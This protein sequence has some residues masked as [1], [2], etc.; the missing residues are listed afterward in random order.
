MQ[1]KQIIFVGIDPA[2]RKE[3]FAVAILDEENTVRFK[4]FKNGFMDFIGW[5]LN[6]RPEH[7]VVGVENSNMEKALFARHKNSVAAAMN[8]GKNQA[9]SQFTVDFCRGVIGKDKVIQISPSQK[10]KKI[11]NDLFFRG[12]VRANGHRLD[13]TYRGLQKEQDKRDAYVILTQA[14]TAYRMRRRY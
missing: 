12:L 5:M 14:R 4:M 6:D 7:L 11:T 13:E 10:G 1:F 3:G 8:V 2:F 9:A